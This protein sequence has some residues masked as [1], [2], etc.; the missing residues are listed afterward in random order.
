LCVECYQASQHEGH[1]VIFGQ[2]FSFAAA[3]DCGDPAAWKK[4]K[5]VGCSHHP[6]LPEGTT[7]PSYPSGYTTSNR[8]IPPALIKALYDTIVIILEFSMD[9]LEHSL[10]MS[11]H[12][13][14]PRDHEELYNGNYPGGTSAEAD[15][16]TTASGPW[17]VVYWASEK[18][19]MKEVTRQIR[20]TLGVSWEQAEHLAREAEQV[21]ST[22]HHTSQI[23]PC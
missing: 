22:P 12:S 3:C 23:D 20:D 18:H 7:P 9:I 8:A 14:L 17:S 5:N 2:S 16:V 13:K 19:L 10:L 4:G 1:E 15:R 11:E 6:P 21:V